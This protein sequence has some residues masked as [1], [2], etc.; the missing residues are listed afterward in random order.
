MLLAG[1]GPLTPKICAISDMVRSKSARGLKDLYYSYRDIA[2]GRM[3]LASAERSS[4][5]VD[6]KIC[7]RRIAALFWSVTVVLYGS[8]GMIFLF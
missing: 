4:T 7:R 2:T 1:L 8:S 5:M 6:L 3:R